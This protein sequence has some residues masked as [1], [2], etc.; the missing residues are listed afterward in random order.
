MVLNAD[1]DIQV[2]FALVVGLC[3]SPEEL[4]NREGLQVIINGV[5]EYDLTREFCHL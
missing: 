1:K 3:Q 4:N 5:P 2:Q